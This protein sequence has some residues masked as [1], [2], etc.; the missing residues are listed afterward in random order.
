MLAKS[1]K[2]LVLKV[3]DCGV[4]TTGHIQYSAVNIASHEVDNYAAQLSDI[5]KYLEC[6][7]VEHMLVKTADGNRFDLWL[8]EVG[9]LENLRPCIPLIFE[10]HICDIIVGNVLV[11]R[12]NQEGDII[13]LTNEDINAFLDYLKDCWKIAC[14]P[15]K[16]M[17]NLEQTS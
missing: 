5:R 15:R 13:T 1:L 8:N 7:Y 14:E 2:A 17:L 9:K 6:K 11:T 3:D 12:C 16:S 4:G 10:D